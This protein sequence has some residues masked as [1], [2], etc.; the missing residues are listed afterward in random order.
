MPAYVTSMKL[1]FLVQDDEK[2]FVLSAIYNDSFMYGLS[3]SLI[4][5]QHVPPVHLA[6]VLMAQ[7][8]VRR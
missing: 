1:Y 4:I 7:K 8:L 2:N 6:G 5:P 3:Y